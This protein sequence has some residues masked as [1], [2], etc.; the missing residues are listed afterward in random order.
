MIYQKLA[1]RL[2]T[3]KE[4]HAYLMEKT[5]ELKDTDLHA[6]IRS[7]E[8]LIKYL[9]KHREVLEGYM[10]RFRFVSLLPSLEITSEIIAVLH[11]ILRVLQKNTTK[12][13]PACRSEEAIIAANRSYKTINKLSN[14]MPK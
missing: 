7:T 13:R 3:L 5:S 12:P 14:L 4:M 9:Y 6:E 10:F 11:N 2:A 8:K 1:I